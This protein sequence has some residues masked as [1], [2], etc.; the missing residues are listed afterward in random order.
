MPQA[1]GIGCVARTDAASLWFFPWPVEKDVN[2]STS[3][4]HHSHFWRLFN[5]K[6]TSH[7]SLVLCT[8]TLRLQVKLSSQRY[9]ICKDD[10]PTAGLKTNLLYMVCVKRVNNRPVFYVWTSLIQAQ[11]PLL[12]VCHS[13]FRW[14]V[15]QSLGL[16]ASFCLSIV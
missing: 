6:F 5:Q 2:T 7:L 14:V 13:I 8:G 12:S 16:W 3:P 10:F 9:T 15:M 11:H 1:A 4:L